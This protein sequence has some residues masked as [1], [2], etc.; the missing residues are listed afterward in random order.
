MD[1]LKCKRCH[2]KKTVDLFSIRGN[3][4]QRYKTCKTCCNRYKCEL[5][6][7]TCSANSLL[8]RH[9]KATHLKI[10]DFKCEQCDYAFSA[11]SDLKQHIKMVHDKIKDFKCELCD[12]TC[13]ANGNLKIHTK[14]VHLKIRDF[15]CEL[16]DYAFSAKSDLK[17]HIKMVHLK[18]KDF[19]CD[20]C[21]YVCSKNGTLK[22][23]IKTCTGEL[24]ISGGELATRKALELLDIEY[25]TEV[26]VIPNL[27]LRFDFEIYIDNQ[28]HYIEYDGRQHFMPVRF[29]GISQEKAELNFI[30]AQERDKIK[31]DWCK[32]NNLKLLRIPY[33]EFENIFT[34]IK[35]WVE[36]C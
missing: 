34:I 16:C 13:S 28:P 8:D 22:I 7:Y 9:I 32:D 1:L 11:K 21:D 5:C 24:K 12:Y 27:N 3:T 20:Q 23:H 33:T 4:G 30:S 35:N 31:N 15:K 26:S 25:K 36:A 14:Q 2:T 17:Q 19:K 18:I 10:K 29:G 6:D